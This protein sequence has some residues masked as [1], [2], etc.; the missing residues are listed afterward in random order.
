MAGHSKWANIKRKKGA[1]DAKRGKLWTKLLREVQVASKLGGPDADANPRLRDAVSEAKSSNVPKDNIERAIKRGA[2]NDDHSSFEEIT[3]EGYGPAGVAM[4]IECLT[5][6]RNRSIADV[7]AAVTKRGGNIGESG[8]VAWM[9]AKK[10]VITILK[11]NSAEEKLMD[12]ALEAGA[13]DIKDEGDVWE[14]LTETTSFSDVK[15]ALES[16]NISIESASITAIPS[17]TVQIAGDDAEKML[18]LLDVLE[19]LDDVQKVYA[20]F[21]MDESEIERLS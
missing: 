9:F 8:S 17:N 12:V 2:G 6:N 15:E 14:V 4:L 3:Y 13:E 10:G 11:E 21:D 16:E 18:K 7:R 19:D 1:N 20:N 5:D